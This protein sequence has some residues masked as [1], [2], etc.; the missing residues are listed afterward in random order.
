[1][2]ARWKTGFFVFFIVA[3]LLMAGWVVCYFRTQRKASIQTNTSRPFTYSFPTQAILT[4]NNAIEKQTGA[5][6]HYALSGTVV[7]G[8]GD[9]QYG[10]RP[11]GATGDSTLPQLPHSESL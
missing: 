11:A 2:P 8:S 1:M 7:I 5:T 6:P 4:Y 3:L 10:L 9:S